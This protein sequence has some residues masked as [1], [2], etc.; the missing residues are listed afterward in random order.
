VVLR[1]FRGQLTMLDSRG[2]G[3]GGDSYPQDMGS[4]GGMSGGPMG[5]PPRDDL[6]DEI[7]F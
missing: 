5:G 2:G 7:P 4:S 6:D 1:R 3:G